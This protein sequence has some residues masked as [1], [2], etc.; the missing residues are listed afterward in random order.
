M[1]ETGIQGKLPPFEGGEYFPDKRI[2]EEVYFEELSARLHHGIF[3]MAHYVSYGGTSLNKKSVNTC[4]SAL[5][6]HYRPEARMCSKKV[7]TC[8]SLAKITDTPVYCLCC[9]P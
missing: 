3:K 5:L 1:R 2:Q 9:N 7:L 6:H 8:R 4:I